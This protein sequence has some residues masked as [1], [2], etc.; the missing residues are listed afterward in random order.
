MKVQLGETFVMETN[1]RFA[2]HEGP[3]FTPEAMGTLKT[4]AGPVYIEGAKPGDTL[5]VE[6]IYASLPL[7]YVWI[8]ATPGLEPAGDKIPEFRKT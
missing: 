8:G 6:V 3:N 5:K 2:T 1:N 7:D 4:M